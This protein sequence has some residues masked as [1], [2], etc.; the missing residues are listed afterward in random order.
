MKAYFPN[1]SVALRRAFSMASHKLVENPPEVTLTFDNYE[2]LVAFIKQL[3]KELEPIMLY[4]GPQTSN[5]EEFE[6]TGI[7]YKLKVKERIQHVQPH[8]QP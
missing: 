7:K 3:E 2:L 4:I 6:L 1:A 5:W 8:N